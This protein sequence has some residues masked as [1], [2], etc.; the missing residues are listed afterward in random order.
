MEITASPYDF[1]FFLVCFVLFFNFVLLL[2]VNERA[3]KFKARYFE[4]IQRIE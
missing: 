1:F 4:N 3:H 2:T